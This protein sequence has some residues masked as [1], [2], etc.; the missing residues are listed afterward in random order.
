[1]YNGWWERKRGGALAKFGGKGVL[2]AGCG[3]RDPNEALGPN[4]AQESWDGSHASGWTRTSDPPTTW[5]GTHSRT[6]GAFGGPLSRVWDE[7]KRPPT[8]TTYSF[9]HPC[10][11]AARVQRVRVLS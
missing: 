2:I 4:R 11:R 10:R 5:G 3:K 7:M 8:K 9:L 1:V 6:A